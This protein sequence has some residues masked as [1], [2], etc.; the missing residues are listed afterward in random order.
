MRLEGNDLEFYHFA[1][2]AVTTEKLSISLTL[3]LYNDR[4]ATKK[5]PTTLSN[6]VC[7]SYIYTYITFRLF[8]NI[9]LIGT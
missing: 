9:A 8:T 2:Q 1:K 3:S 5:M 6:Y 7:P 4:T